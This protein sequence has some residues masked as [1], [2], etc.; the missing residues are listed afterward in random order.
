MFFIEYDD[1]FMGVDMFRIALCDDNRSFLEYESVVIY[2]HLTKKDVLSQCDT[3]ISGE[4]LLAKGILIKNYDLFILDYDMDGLTGF[5]TARR[6]YEIYP[7]AKIAFATNYYDFTREGY[8]YNAVRYLVKQEKTFASELKECVDLLFEKEPKKTIVIELR[9]GNK[10]LNIDEIVY[11]RSDKHYIRFFIKD[12]DSTYFEWRCSLDDIQAELP[13]YF[14]R[15]H[16]RFIINLK[17]VD[18]IQRY[19]LTIPKSDGKPLKFP[20]SRNRYDDVNEK[21]CLMKGK[22]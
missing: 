1:G 7:D 19:E 8:R 6:I 4:E 3:F 22:F 15:I 16:Q 2:D 14:V 11:I 5:E 9:D 18:N 21:Y 13:Q 10:E 12:R 17:Y 20:I